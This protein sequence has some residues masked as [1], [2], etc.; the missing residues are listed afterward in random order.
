MRVHLRRSVPTAAGRVQG[1]GLPRTL[2]GFGV[3]LTPSPQPFRCVDNSITDILFV[4]ILFVLFSLLP[5][6]KRSQLV[7]KRRI[8]WEQFLKAF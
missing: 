6:R 7:I 1:L 5:K 4:C 8:R 2:A 3:F